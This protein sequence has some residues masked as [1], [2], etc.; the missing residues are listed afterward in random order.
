[1]DVS[2]GS[3]SYVA[4]HLYLTTSKEHVRVACEPA[5]VTRHSVITMVVIQH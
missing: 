3:F 1:M 2:V 5:V 4:I